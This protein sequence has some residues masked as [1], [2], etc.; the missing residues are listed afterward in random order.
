[1]R[2]P[3][4][5]IGMPG[6]AGANTQAATRPAASDNFTRSHGAKYASLGVM[7]ADSGQ[8]TADSGRK[9]SASNSELRVPNPELCPR[10]QFDVVGAKAHTRG[11]GGRKAETRA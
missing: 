7:A 11:R 9:V 1:M 10:T 6:A 8:W 4:A 5:K 3:G 2:S